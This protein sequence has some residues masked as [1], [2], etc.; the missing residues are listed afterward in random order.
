MIP[1]LM[2]PFF[3]MQNLWWQYLNME[4]TDDPRLLL[5]RYQKKYLE[6]YESLKTEF[7][8]AVSQNIS[9]VALKKHLASQAKN[10]R[11]NS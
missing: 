6:N 10:N 5:S 8:S 1:Q 2:S 7:R 4:D 9:F 3:E 11:Y